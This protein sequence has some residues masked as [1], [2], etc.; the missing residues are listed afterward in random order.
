MWNHPILK[1]IL[2]IYIGWGAWHW[3][4]SRP[5]REPDGVLAE[6]EPQQSNLAEDQ[7]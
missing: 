1:V 3:A 4:V 5:V 7:K 6:G 2:L